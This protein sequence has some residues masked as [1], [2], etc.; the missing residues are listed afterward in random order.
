M[1][2]ESIEDSIRRNLKDAVQT[3]RD[4]CDEAE[5]RGTAGNADKACRGVMHKLSWGFA[6]ASSCIESAMA[7]LEEKHGMELLEAKEPKA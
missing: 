3:M 1:S 7:W 4:A 5:R 6:N 2:I